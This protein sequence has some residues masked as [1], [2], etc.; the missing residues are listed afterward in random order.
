MVAPLPD[1]HLIALESL[2]RRAAKQ[3][4]RSLS[5]VQPLSAAQIGE[6]LDVLSGPFGRRGWF[7]AF[8]R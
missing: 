4:Y 7:S 6:L 2:R 1:C 5:P 8:E 3:V